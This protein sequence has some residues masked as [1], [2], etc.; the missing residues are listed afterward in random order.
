MKKVTY[1][2]SNIFSLK[3]Y[4]DNNLNCQSYEYPT[5]YGVRCAILGAIIQTE[6]IE[7][8][9][10]LFNKIKNTNIYIQYSQEL[11]VNG[12]KQSRYS[13]AY[14]SKFDE[15][16][17]KN[18]DKTTMG[19][20]QYIKMD[21]IV[22]Y[23]DNLIPD[24][25]MYL[26]NIDWLGTAESMVYLDNIEEVD[27]LNNILTRWNKESHTETFEQHDWN[28]KTTFDT[29]YMYSSK[30]KHNHD[31]FMCCINDIVLTS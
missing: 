7:K 29:V 23:I 28:G 15:L 31:T 4:N 10:E 13:N 24:I 21:E 26:K 2:L 9:K 20:R 16:D 17:S 11:K 18:F 22:F 8:A 27:K 12:I 6:G 30:Q 19:F 1:K 3:K 5:I 14:Y 25:D